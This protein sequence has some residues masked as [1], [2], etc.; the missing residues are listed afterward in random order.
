MIND[1]DQLTSFSLY[2]ST[3]TKLT[4]LNVVLNWQAM[5]SFM[6]N[7]SY[8]HSHST[9]LISSQKTTFAIQKNN[10]QTQSMKYSFALR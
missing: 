6:S 10:L 4:I 1:N 5:L 7:T 2:P 3:H 8:S 9:S